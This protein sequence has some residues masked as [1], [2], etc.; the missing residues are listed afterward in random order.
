[1]TSVNTNM[2]S[3]LAMKNMDKQEKLMT[4]A[5]ER[6][7]SGLRINNASDDAAGSAIAS[8]MTAQV[9]SLDQAIRNGNDA[10]SLT[11]T[12]EGALGEIENILQRIREL[13]V[14][15]GNSTLNAS[16]R[17]QIQAEIDAL[18][19]E[20]DS[21]SS[22]TNFNKVKLLD[23][24]VDEV[25]MQIGIDSSDALDISLKKTDVAALGI[26]SASSTSVNKII[27]ARMTRMQSTIAT[28]DIKINGKNFATSDFDPSSVTIQGTAGV[29]V[30][31]ALSAGSQQAAALAA[32]INE[33][34]GEHGV[35]ARAFN[36]IKS[37]SNVYTKGAMTINAISITAQDTKE[38]FVAAVNDRVSNVDASIDN[39]GFI[40]FSNNDG[41]TI[42]FS[43]ATEVGIAN[44]DYGGFVELTSINGEPITIQAGTKT[45]GFTGDTG[46]TADVTD[47][48][49]NEMVLN[50][51][52]NGVKVTGSRA[53]DG[54]ALAA[55]DGLKIN[56][57]LIGA[58]ASAS[59]ID[60]AK[61]INKLTAEHGVTA[62]AATSVLLEVDLEVSS[63]TVANHTG[64]KIMGV[65]VSMGTVDSLN[66]FITT[67]NTALSGVTDV[68]ATADSETGKVILTSASGLTI[69]A[70]DTAT[71]G[72][73]TGAGN[74]FKSVTNLDG[75]A[76]TGTI[77]NGSFSNRGFISL[78]SADGSAVKIED[79]AKDRD[80]QDG[81]TRIGFEKQN[82]ISTGATGVN[83]GTVSQ[84]SSALSS[85]DNAINTISK[86][87]ASFG[88]MENRLEAA[89]NNL[90]TLQVNTDAS[91]SRIEDADFA[92]ETSKL[93]K[94]QILSQAATSMLAQ[95]NASKQS[96]LAL[97][98]G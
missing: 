84:A 34:T 73:D 60:K 95:A 56:D 12:A 38:E 37:T 85:I 61:A 18:S 4:T 5:M 65:T 59:A 31:A 90:V 79:G 14:Q 47:I 36:E 81:A 19:S 23:G 27:S 2:G 41:D 48:G 83:V 45:N 7:S 69:T 1:M 57:V 42:T 29:D 17:S 21:I 44:D 76:V 28:T 74:L 54:T 8:K 64:A 98:Q 10:I 55:S 39:D 6:L 43:G 22:K 87:R 82:E 16:D 80:G 68:V 40:V 53:V 91:R 96:L 15:A 88:A 89:I 25:T 62:T 97:L 94:S 78:T 9:R 13:S 20:I 93:T 52:G 50:E 92:A 32:K 71:P 3:L 46:E 35:K 51:G 75:S 70:Q 49:F 66:E 26:G 77:S 11:Q 86:F 33:N 67:V 63:I 72:S 30:S 58:S 24:T